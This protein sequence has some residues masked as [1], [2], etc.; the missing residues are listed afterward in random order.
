M[1]ICPCWSTSTRCENCRAHTRAALGGVAAARGQWWAEAVAL[2][3]GT[4][5]EWPTG[6]ERVHTIARSKVHDLASGDDELANAFAALVEEYAA[7][8]WERLQAMPP[9]IVARF[10]MPTKKRRI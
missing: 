7:A 10:R 5:R 9:E 1:A 6:T 4:S 8:R 2:K 3:V